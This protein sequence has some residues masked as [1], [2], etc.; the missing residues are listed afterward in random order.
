MSDNILRNGHEVAE[1]AAAG[2]LDGVLIEEVDLSKSGMPG[3][4]ASDVT[5][6]RLGLHA[7]PANEGDYS[8]TKFTESSLRG[9]TFSD[10]LF[11]ACSYFS[12]E[13]IEAKFDGST[14]S[15]TSFFNC[16]MGN[17]SFSGARLTSANFNGCELFGADFSRSLLVN[18]R[19]DAPDRGN[20]TLD[21][22]NFS[23]AI[24]VD[25]D[26]MGANF[27]GATFTDALLIKVDLRHANLS[28][29][30]FTGAHL[31]D[32]HIDTSMLE[33]GVARAVEAARVDDPWRRQGF[34]KEV[35]ELHSNDEMQMLLEYV[36]RTYVIE[37]AQPAEP[38]DSFAMLLTQL[39]G[40][41]DFSELDRLRLRGTAVQVQVDGHWYDMLGS[42]PSAVEAAP[43]PEPATAPIPANEPGASSAT[44]SE[45][46]PT[47]AEATSDDAPP[48]P[49]PPPKGVA[50]SKRFRSLEID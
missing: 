12:S 34:M 40:R 16:R 27:Y 9:A 19:F 4:T 20:V 42:G 38:A 14:L 31:I 35:L 3:V 10:S 46:A 30:D 7:A 29:A 21:R 37:G 2:T 11:R 33:P 8:R 17:S 43:M 6:R 26:L 50:R 28:E 13:L 45:P 23:N 49:K 25:C 44:P 1:M 15:N 36:L 41:Y 48:A 24:L 18:S 22:S 5:F 39:K 32:V 47:T